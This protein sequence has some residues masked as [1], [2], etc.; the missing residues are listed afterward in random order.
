MGN[1]IF[2][3]CIVSALRGTTR[4]FTRFILVKD[5]KVVEMASRKSLLANS[6]SEFSGLVRAAAVVAALIINAEIKSKSASS[7]SGEL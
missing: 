4:L 3:N 7:T 5:G 1:D 6:M 2:A